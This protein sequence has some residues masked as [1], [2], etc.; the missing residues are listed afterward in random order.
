MQRV[1]EIS[2]FKQNLSYLPSIL[3]I[4]LKMIYAIYIYY[5]SI[6]EYTQELQLYILT[7]ISMPLYF[8]L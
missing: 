5:F 7:I 3:R 8:T 2:V 6:V 4:Y 1:S